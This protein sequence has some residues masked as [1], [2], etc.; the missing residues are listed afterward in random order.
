MSRSLQLRASILAAIGFCTM[1]IADS[2]ASMSA[3]HSR[4]VKF[5]RGHHVVVG[6]ASSGG[7]LRPK[8]KFLAHLVTNKQIFHPDE[9]VYFRVENIG[10]RSIGLIGEPFSV[11]RFVEGVWA[12]DPATPDGFHKVRWGRVSSGKAG[13][14]QSVFLPSSMTSGGYRISKQISLGESKKRRLFVEFKVRP[15]Y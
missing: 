11:E 8:A 7:N 2:S 1:M 15:R 9:T 14:C 12:K 5:C 6:D 10:Q 4:D 13:P 3:H